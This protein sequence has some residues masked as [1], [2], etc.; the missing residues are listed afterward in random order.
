M[1]IGLFGHSHSVCLMDAIGDWRG[2]VFGNRKLSIQ[3]TTARSGFAQSFDDWDAT[4][5]SDIAIQLP[6]SKVGPLVADVMGFVISGAAPYYALA[7]LNGAS[8]AISPTLAKIAAAFKDCDLVVSIAFGN[9]LATPIWLDDLPRYDFIEESVPGPL[10]AEAQPVSR[11]YIDTICRGF[12]MRAYP[13][14][15]F[16]RQSCPNS[17]VIHLLPPPPLED[18][19]GLK[20]HEGF[21][22]KLAKYGTLD[23]KVR[24]KWFRSY[25]RATVLTLSPLGVT[26][27]PPPMAAHTPRGFFRDELSSGLTHGNTRYGAMVWE[28]VAA[29]LGVKR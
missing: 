25:V 3:K 9:E 8:V 4:D 2:Q 7:A 15:A 28:N 6:G 23:S 18:P 14:C 27:L 21:A 5:T 26:V 1:K 17:K 10:R 24:L 13:V 16:L 12:A 11:K 22:P 19:S 29:H 20:L